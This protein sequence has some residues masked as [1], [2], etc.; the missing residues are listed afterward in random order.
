MLSEDDIEAL[1]QE[2]HRIHR[3]LEGLASGSS[4]S[5]VEAAWVEPLPQEAA[6]LERLDEIEFAL[7]ENEMLH[8]RWR[9]QGMR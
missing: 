3:W 4:R 1:G 7:G 5:Y 6:F 8:R 2:W 9:V